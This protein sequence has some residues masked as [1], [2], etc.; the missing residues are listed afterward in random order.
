MD[1]TLDNLTDHGTNGATCNY[2]PHTSSSSLRCLDI[3]HR[4]DTAG[5]AGKG[6][7]RLLLDTGTDCNM[8]LRLCL[9]TGKDA[10]HVDVEHAVD[11]AVVAG[12][13]GE[14]PVA[15]VA[16][17][18]VVVAHEDEIV[19]GVDTAPADAL[20]EAKVASATR[21]RH[22]LFSSSQFS[23]RFAFVKLANL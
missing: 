13:A 16:R 4:L 2:S 12:E 8:L 21:A 23:T 6:M 22:L 17:A 20:R 15:E 1:D 18:G 19:L 5:P 10:S 14:W 9:D 7:L 11:A 3:G